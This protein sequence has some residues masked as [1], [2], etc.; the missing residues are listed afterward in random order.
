MKGEVAQAKEKKPKSQEHDGRALV[1][2]LEVTFGV[3]ILILSYFKLK[4]INI[5]IN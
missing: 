4:I 2:I 5:N 1:A 3:S